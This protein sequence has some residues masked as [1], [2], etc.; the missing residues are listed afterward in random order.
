MIRIV[1]LGDEIARFLSLYL[2]Y[3]Y[4]NADRER[5]ILNKVNQI[6]GG[7]CLWVVVKRKMSFA[8]E[9]QCL[10][11]ISVLAV[12]HFSLCG[13]NIKFSHDKYFYHLTF[14]ERESEMKKLKCER[15]QKKQ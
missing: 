1:C 3:C 4:L 5:K 15:N 7:G 11:S 12:S 6:L 8:Y 9:I 10:I 2:D 14:R 13:A